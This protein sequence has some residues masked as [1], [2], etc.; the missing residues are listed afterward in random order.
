MKLK[1]AFSILSS[2]MLVS[3][4]GV[5]GAS[6]AGQATV[7]VSNVATSDM[8]FSWDGTNHNVPANSQIVLEVPTGNHTF[9]AAVQGWPDTSGKIDLAFGQTFSLANHLEKT[10]PVFDANG[11]V[12][13]QVEYAGAWI[14]F[15]QNDT[16]RLAAQPVPA[17]YGGLVFEN[18][19]GTQLTVNLGGDTTWTVPVQGRVQF[20]LP[21]GEYRYTV[22]GT[23]DGFSAGY[24]A[25]ARVSAGQYTGLG[26]DRDLSQNESR[27]TKTQYPGTS[28]KKESTDEISGNGLDAHGDRILKWTML[29][30]NVPLP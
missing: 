3:L 6:A 19:I 12:I 5:M 2:L 24:N 20:D 8:G 15:I 28:T 13:N 16:T 27:V 26:F 9:K 25:I 21:A 11:T 18:Y 10:G 22:S 14:E 30:T 23:Q 7:V 1:S 29:V 4:V 17:G